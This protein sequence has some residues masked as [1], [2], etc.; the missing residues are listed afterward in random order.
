MNSS[1][2]ATTDGVHPE[3][4]VFTD[5]QKMLT[6]LALQ[7]VSI[8]TRVVWYS[9]RALKQWRAKKRAIASVHYFVDEERGFDISAQARAGD[10]EGS[11]HSVEF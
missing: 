5:S 8:V 10:T 2:I 7:I 3:P 6:I 1:E 9:W 11:F 4:W